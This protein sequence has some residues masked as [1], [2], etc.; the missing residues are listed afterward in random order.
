VSTRRRILTLLITLV[1]LTALVVPAQATG[2]AFDERTG[3][4]SDARY[5]LAVVGD[6]P[7]GDP[8]VAAFPRFVDFINRDPRVEL[9]AHLGDIKSGSSLCSDEYFLFVKQ[10]LNR[11]NDPVVYTPGDNEWTD[12]HRANNGNYKPTERLE[13]LRSLFF[14]VPGKTI[15][16]RQRFVLTQALDPRHRPYRENV[17][18]LESR[19]VFATLNVP[20]SNDDS[21]E[22]NPWTG[23]WAGSPDQAAE[24]RARDAANLDWLRA[25]FA[26]AR[27]VR[28]KGVVLMLQADM[29]DTFGTHATLEDFDNLVKTIGE[30]SKEFG[31]PVLM[32]AGDSHVFKVDNPYDGSP[33]HE[34]FHPGFTPVAPNLTRIVVEGST[35]EPTRFDYLRLT[36][37][38]R[39]ARLFSWDRV[40]CDF[41]AGT[42]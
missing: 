5:T 35:T 31:K 39:G 18:W 17:M 28:A 7:Y 38:P 33:E 9:V 16:G 30:A 13:K 42:C 26:A 14:P 20:G 3:R 21:P 32:L 36:L 15:G 40:A 29:W 11:L 41:V 22:T 23:A 37:D 25:T 10:Q 34:A 12:C 8:K 6:V 2:I 4:D 1:A 27:L 24:Q 19:V